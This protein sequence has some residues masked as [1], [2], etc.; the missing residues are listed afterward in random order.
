M[1]ILQLDSSMCTK[2]YIEDTLVVTGK[3]NILSTQNWVSRLRRD[4]G[5]E[6]DFFESSSLSL[7]T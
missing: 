3:S 5:S 6:R 2:V 4:L 7:T 1:S